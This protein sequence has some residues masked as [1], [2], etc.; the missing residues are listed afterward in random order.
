M[1]QGWDPEVK[2]YFK[3]IMNTI[4]LGLL[5]LMMVLTAGLYFR[6][7]YHGNLISTILFYAA[8]LVS[9]FFLIRYYCR[10]WK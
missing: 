3:K 7:A 5:W 10:I 9:L 1:E 4:A 8:V 6:M 2:R